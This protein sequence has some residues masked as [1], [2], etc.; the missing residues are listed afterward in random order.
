MNIRKK[1]KKCK[2]TEKFFSPKKYF[3]VKIL[4]EYLFLKKKVPCISDFRFEDFDVFGPNFGVFATQSA[5]R[6]SG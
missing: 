1:W 5:R 4:V 3:K 6:H 2:F